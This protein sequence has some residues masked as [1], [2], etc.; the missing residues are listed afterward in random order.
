MGTKLKKRTVNT[1]SCSSSLLLLPLSNLFVDH[2]SKQWRSFIIIWK[3]LRNI[4]IKNRLSWLLNT[5]SNCLLFSLFKLIANRWAWELV[6][7]RLDRN[8][9]AL[10]IARRYPWQPCK[11][12]PSPNAATNWHC[13]SDRIQWKIL[14]WPHTY[15]CI[16]GKGWAGSQNTQRSAQKCQR[17][18][19]CKSQDKQKAAAVTPQIMYAWEADRWPHWLAI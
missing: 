15:Q 3:K 1:C 7:S 17:E 6:L 13:H 10:G 18:M 11:W 5:K 2:N 12:E 9:N 8:L 14:S 4:P 16:E 19:Q